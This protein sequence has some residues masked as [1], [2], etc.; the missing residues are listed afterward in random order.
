LD[1]QKVTFIKHSLANQTLTPE[2]MAEMF[3]CS[4]DDI[5]AANDS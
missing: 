4:V 5:K 2:K 3:A 1:E